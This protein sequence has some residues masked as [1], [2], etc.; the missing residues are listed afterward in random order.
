[1]KCVSINN[2]A[3]CERKQWTTCSAICILPLFPTHICRFWWY[4]RSFGT[5]E[6][7]THIHGH[8]VFHTCCLG[9]QQQMRFFF[10]KLF[11]RPKRSHRLLFC[12]SRQSQWGSFFFK[13]IWDHFFGSYFGSILERW[14][15]NAYIYFYIDSLE[16]NRF[17]CQS[18]EK[19]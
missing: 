12:Y 3:P 14:D 18:L 4:S 6:H 5:F 17:V 8:H 7:S 16:W 10:S 13:T 9:I 15:A 2:R 11:Y 19:L 1:M